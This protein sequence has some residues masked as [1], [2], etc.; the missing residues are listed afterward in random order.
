MAS[1]V[2]TSAP[3][4]SPRLTPESIAGWERYVGATELR[5]AREL[6]A[7]DRFLADD[8]AGGGP[9]HRRALLAGTVIV[10]P[11]TTVDHTGAP[12]DVPNAMVHHWRGGIFIPGV[13]LNDLMTRLYA[14][15]PTAREQEDILDSR[16]LARGRDQMNIYLKLQRTKI[17]TVVYNTEHDV[18]FKRQSATRASST[19]T[20][21][22]IA[23]LDHPGEPREK[24]LPAGDDSGYLWRWNTYWR[25]EEVPGGVLAECESVS[26]SRDVPGVI[27]ALAG[28]IIRSTASES[29][30]RTLTGLRARHAR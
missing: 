2:A 29:M 10:E 19:S 1:A 28:P 16:V 9:A 5:I 26:L 11:V 3:V 4:G 22:K 8:F 7:G 17:V 18:R 24:E 23:E 21:T 25:Y 6:G 30:E 15:P 13:R 14:G 12:I 27:R 20:A